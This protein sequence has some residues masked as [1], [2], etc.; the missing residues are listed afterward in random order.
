MS[1]IFPKLG[2]IITV[3]AKSGGSD[4]DMNSKLRIAIINAKAQNMPKDNIQAAIKRANDK[5]L[6]DIRE[7]NYEAKAKH[8]VLL[9]IECSTNNGTRTVAN[10]KHILKKGD[11]ESLTNGS[12]DFMFTRKSVIVCDKS[13]DMDLEELELDLID[14]GLESVEEDKI[15]VVNEDDKNIIRIYGDFPSFGKLNHIL[16]E[17]GIN[18]S[19][20]ETPRIANTPIELDDEQLEDIEKLIENLEDDE[21][22][23]HVYTNIN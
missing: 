8:G 2:K 7:I 13:D 6:G 1:R 4:P 14:Y 3:A 23:A 15:P 20:S 11:A 19:K 10:I 21:D 17:K 5:D 18:I 16:E 12:L 22:V 9:F